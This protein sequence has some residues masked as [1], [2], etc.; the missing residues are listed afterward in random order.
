MSRME[1]NRELKEISKDA[2]TPVLG[3]RSGTNRSLGEDVNGAYED[4]NHAKD[5]DLSSIRN[6]ALWTEKDYFTLEGLH[7]HKN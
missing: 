7:W 4:I 5:M 3:L 6:I 2:I 1:R